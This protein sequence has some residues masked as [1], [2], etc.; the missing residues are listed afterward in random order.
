M[1]S[2]DSGRDEGLPPRLG[3]CSSDLGAGSLGYAHKLQH[4]GGLLVFPEIVLLQPA[5]LHREMVASKLRNASD[6][7]RD[8]GGAI[9][10]PR[11]RCLGRMS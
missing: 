9:A 5:G 4:G 10:T 3:A 8:L 11:G 7:A 2:C 1:A 6:F